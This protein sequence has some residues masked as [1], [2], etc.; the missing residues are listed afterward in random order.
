MKTTARSHSVRPPTAPGTA[1][2]RLAKGLIALA[3][4]ACSSDPA[5]PGPSDAQTPAPDGGTRDGG[6][7]D[8]NAI[9][10]T[11]QF[12]LTPP[13]ADGPDKR[14]GITRF[15]GGVRDRPVLDR[16][17]FK[18]IAEQGT[19]VAYE[20]VTPFCSPACMFGSTCSADDVCTADGVAISVGNVKVRGIATTPPTA[21][22]V[23]MPAGNSS[24]SEPDGISLKFPPFDLGAPIELETAGGALPPLRLSA[25]G[26]TFL[27]TVGA[28]TVRAAKGE[29]LALRWKPTAMPD[30][31][32]I[33]IKLDLSHHGGTKG[34]L[35]CDVPDN[36]SFD[37]PAALMTKLIDLGVAGYPY[38]SLT[39]HV[40]NAAATP[41]GR[42]QL[43]ITSEVQVVLNIPGFIS[44]SEAEPCPTGKTCGTDRLCR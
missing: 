23:M 43:Q 4:A 3:I 33:A 20:T 44:C 17:I 29:V 2:A 40:T 15:I 8:P 7:S 34:K 31:S 16:L 38:A 25:K 27:E 9:I 21:E 6:A 36:G 39:R 19:C 12:I 13:I 41:K 24:Y 42:V 22:I 11:F 10:G 37:V 28:P 30:V 32:R 5:K 35:E 14:D 26:T 18:K 1:Y